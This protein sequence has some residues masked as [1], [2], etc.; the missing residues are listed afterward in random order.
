MYPKDYYYN[1]DE[2]GDS[3]VDADGVLHV[4]LLSISEETKCPFCGGSNIKKIGFRKKKGFMDITAEGA[5]VEITFKLQRYICEDCAE[6]KKANENSKVQTTFTADCLPDCIRKNKQISTDMIDAIVKKVAREHMSI[7][8]T[9]DSMHVSAAS[10]S[11]IISKHRKAAMEQ[12]ST[13]EAADTLIIYPFDYSKKER[14]AIIGVL[15]RHPILYTILKDCEA[16]SVRMYLKKTPFELGHFPDSSLTD[17]PRPKLY[18]V[19]SDLYDGCE[20]GIL[21][22][23]TLKRMKELR[24]KSWSA[25]DSVELD[26]A[27]EDLGRIL[28][29]HFYD[30]SAEE[31]VPIDLNNNDFYEF[32]S[33]RDLAFND[34]TFEALD[35]MLQNWWSDLSPNMKHHLKDI[36]DGLVTN[37]EKVNVGLE[38]NESLYSPSVLLQCIEKLRRNRVPFNDLLSWLALV[39]GVHNKEQI[40]AV[41]MFTSSYV[42]KP[43]HGFYI[44]LLELNALLDE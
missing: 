28:T 17:Y 11:D 2:I 3:V 43:I 5:P 44:D 23:S 6:K 40:T 30:V 22:E 26:F 36:F 7:A 16:S 20:F 19:L 24:D 9:A 13:L 37:I 8:D 41:E 42:P 33:E 35:V 21:R 18:K 12:I 10:V 39:A 38:Y 27:L 1:F 4:E 32:L 31:F 14:C 29:A 34:L 15:N 25:A